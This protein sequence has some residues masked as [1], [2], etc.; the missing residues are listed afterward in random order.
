MFYFSA[1]TGV[2][3]ICV[4]AKLFKSMRFSER[5]E[6]VKGRKLKSLF[7][8]FLFLFNKY[9]K[10]SKE[11]KRSVKILFLATKMLQQHEFTHKMQYPIYC[12]SMSFWCY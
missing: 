9:F 10:T 2:C 1:D 5:Q 4:R 6:I 12:L 3:V 11:V 7:T 8:I